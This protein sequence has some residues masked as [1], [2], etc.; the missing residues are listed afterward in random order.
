MKRYWPCRFGCPLAAPANEENA[1]APAAKATGEGDYDRARAARL[2]NAH[3]ED[4]WKTELRRY[5]DDPM[6]DIVKNVDTVEWWSVSA[7]SAYFHGTSEISAHLEAP[8]CISD[9][10]AHGSGYTGHSRGIGRC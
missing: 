3:A 8:E 10:G 6:A 5:M 7:Y 1:T 4:G 2:R 9:L